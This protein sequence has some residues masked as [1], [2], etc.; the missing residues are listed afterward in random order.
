MEI[1]SYLT[2]WIMNSSGGLEIFDGLVNY[3]IKFGFKFCYSIISSFM[4][5]ILSSSAGCFL[6]KYNKG[7]VSGVE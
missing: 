4:L 3:Q 5:S 7:E 6:S 1:L 2:Y